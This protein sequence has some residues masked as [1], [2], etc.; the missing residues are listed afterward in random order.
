M[1]HQQT[2]Q[3]SSYKTWGKLDSNVNY[4]DTEFPHWNDYIKMTFHCIIMPLHWGTWIFYEVHIEELSLKLKWSWTDHSNEGQ[5]PQTKSTNPGSGINFT[6]A[7]TSVTALIL[8]H[9]YVENRR[10]PLSFSTLRRT[11]NGEQVILRITD[12][13]IGMFV[14]LWWVFIYIASK[15]QHV[16]WQ[17]CHF[18]YILWQINLVVYDYGRNPHESVK[19]IGLDR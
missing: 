8:P 3:S 2:R 4:I 15:Y 18:L 7:S 16:I 19:R 14:L 17:F 1:I 5:C 11:F 12:A 13:N 9:K 6:P 10:Q